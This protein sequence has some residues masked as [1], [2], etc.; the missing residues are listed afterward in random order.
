MD[1]LIIV[2]GVPRSGTTLLAS[3]L[4]GHPDISMMDECYNKNIFKQIGTKLIGNKIACDGMVCSYKE[5][6]IPIIGSLV[7]RIV[8]ILFRNRQLIRYITVYNYSIENLIYMGAKFII[9]ERNKEDVIDSNV[10]RGKMPKWIAKMKYKYGM[11][12]IRYLKNN[13]DI[14]GMQSEHIVIKYEELL[15]DTNKQLR[16][17]CDFLNVEQLI[18]S[19]KAGA[20]YNV[21]YN[22]KLL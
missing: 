13:Y 6:R 21:R 17:I 22:K 18:Y 11:K 16:D 8:N 19:M 2:I 14:K 4:G 5:V 15:S 12:T 7:N 9:I 1:N 3:M 20:E 10:V